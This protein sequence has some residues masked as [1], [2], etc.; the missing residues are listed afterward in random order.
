MAR[1][2]DTDTAATNRWSTG[3]R[4]PAVFPD[5]TRNTLLIGGIYR[6]DEFLPATMIPLPALQPHLKQIRDDAVLVR[7]A[8]GDG[9]GARRALWQALDH[10]PLIVV[11]NTDDLAAAA[12]GEAIALLLNVLYG[13]LA[14]AVLIAVLG[15]VNTL[16]MSVFERT[17]EI[18]MLRGV[19]R[20]PEQTKQ[21]V[22]LESVLICLFGALL[23]IGAG[24]FL[25]WAAG[26]LA[27]DSIQGYEMTLPWDRIAVA[28]AGAVC[29]GAL[30]ALGPARRAA[31]LNILAALKTN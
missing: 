26:R 2:I 18:G 1:L 3:Q 5:G 28:L 14:M 24:V 11:R 17:R 10:N 6:S 4:V 8:S 30:A 7:T 23:G 25:G 19:G 22:R 9:D 21:M 29:V 12:G 31:R 15:V 20:Q 13:L 27:A 16:A